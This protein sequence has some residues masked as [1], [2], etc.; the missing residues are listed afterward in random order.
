MVDL[1]RKKHE[2]WLKIFFGAMSLP[3]GEAYDRL[4]DFANIEY[5]HLKWLAKEIVK[6]GGDFDWDRENIRLEFR[7]SKELYRYLIEEIKKIQK[8]Y[9][10]GALYDRIR[11]DEAYMLWS[12][13]HMD[14]R[15]PIEAFSKKLSYE[16]LDRQSIDALVQ[17]LFEEIY[18]EYELIIT[19]TYSQIHTDSAKLALIF[20]DLIYE[21]LYHLK[22]FCAI[23]AKLGMLA[24]PRVVM[25]EVYKFDDL[26]KFLEDGIQEE[27][28]AKEQCKAL[29]S[30]IKDEELSRFFEFINYQ[31][32]YHITL[33]QEAL[34]SISS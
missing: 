7:N 20:E 2:L 28:A 17:F 21:S 1:F 31:E 25:K 11:R 15:V 27:L 34:A 30:A 32:D 16:G 9:G 29:S 33:M 5:R 6:N 19:Y 23:A 14:E 24:V 8:L 13:E 18:K 10:E 3:K 12:L 4:L 26:K 22:S